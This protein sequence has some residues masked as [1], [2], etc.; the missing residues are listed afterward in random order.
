MYIYK[1]NI[2]SIRS[3]FFQPGAGVRSISRPLWSQTPNVSEHFVFVRVASASCPALRARAFHFAAIALPDPRHVLFIVGFQVGSVFVRARRVR[4]FNFASIA[5]PDCR[6]E[7]QVYGFSRRLR[8]IARQIYVGARSVLERLGRF[9][10]AHGARP[11][12]LE[13]DWRAVAHDSIEVGAPKRSSRLRWTSE[14]RR[15]VRLV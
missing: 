7:F 1:Q 5:N 2:F 12:V 11:S 9:R 14:A 4:A 6:R 13:L 3:A 10:L 8:R 15:D